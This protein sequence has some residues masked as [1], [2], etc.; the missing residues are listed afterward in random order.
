MRHALKQQFKSVKL[1]E[2]TKV[3]TGL[4]FFLGAQLI[5]AS[6][7]EPVFL[8]HISDGNIGTKVLPKSL[9]AEG[10]FFIFFFNYYWFRGSGGN[11]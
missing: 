3:L 9:R 1:E 11:K 6:C 4:V 8:L 5:V 2:V 7:A 10:L